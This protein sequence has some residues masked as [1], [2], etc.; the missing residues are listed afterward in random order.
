VGHISLIVAVEFFVLDGFTGRPFHF[1]FEYWM[2][3][4]KWAAIN[5]IAKTS[6]I[7]K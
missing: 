6:I 7:D 2:T 1:C 4:F 5:Q 3:R